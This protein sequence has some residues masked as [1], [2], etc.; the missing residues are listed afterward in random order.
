MTARNE[1]LS[2]LGQGSPEIPEMKSRS[3]QYPDMP[4]QFA[5]ALTASKGETFI[6]PSKAAVL[7]QVWELLAELKAESVV[8]QR[9]AP[10]ADLGLPDAFPALKWHFAGEDDEYRTACIHADVGLTSAELA[11]AETGSLVMASGSD[12]AR[13]TTLLPPAHIALVPESRL[14]PSI[15]EWQRDHQG[16][17]PANLFLISG[18]SKTGD[19]EQTP[20][21]GVHGPKRLM[22]VIYREE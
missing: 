15:F 3:R 19:I 12:K 13:M 11:L 16:E 20:I 10:L 4:A 22:V 6:V 21:V 7:D 17:M 2:R 14:I 1:I 5:E 9:D 8:A 18:P